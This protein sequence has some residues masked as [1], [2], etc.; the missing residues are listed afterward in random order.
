M[1]NT[2][3]H[4]IAAHT[5][6]GADPPAGGEDGTEINRYA[7]WCWTDRAGDVAERRLQR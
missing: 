6:A 4:A 7:D 5:A 3:S 1:E 2:L